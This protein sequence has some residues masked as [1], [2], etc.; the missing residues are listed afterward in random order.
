V[1]LTIPL[2]RP[3]DCYDHS[4]DHGEIIGDFL[5]LF[6]QSGTMNTTFE[7]YSLLTSSSEDRSGLP[8]LDS[9]QRESSLLLI[10]N[11]ESQ[12]VFE[13]IYE[14]SMVCN[15]SS[16]SC[17]SLTNEIADTILTFAG[18]HFDEFPTFPD[19]QSISFSDQ[20][21]A[22]N[23]P[24]LTVPIDRD[25]IDGL[26]TDKYSTAPEV[27]IIY[28]NDTGH[29][30]VSD[31]V[32][33]FEGF[34]P[35]VFDYH[36]QFSS[37]LS[38]SEGNFERQQYP[39]ESYF[40]QVTDDPELDPNA[41]SL[42]LNTPF[43]EFSTFSVK[44]DPNES[45]V[46]LKKAIIDLNGEPSFK[47]TQVLKLP[48]QNKIRRRNR[49]VV[50]RHNPKA[51]ND[52]DVDKILRIL[53]QEGLAC[54]LESFQKEDTRS[55]E[56]RKHT[57]SKKHD[58]LR[59][60]ELHFDRIKPK[61]PDFPF[62]DDF[63][64]SVASL[65]GYFQS[66]DYFR[67]SIADG[68]ETVVFLEITNWLYDMGL[69]D[70]HCLIRLVKNHQIPR[71]AR[72][73][74]NQQRKIVL[75]ALLFHTD[76][77]KYPLFK[78]IKRVVAGSKEVGQSFSMSDFTGY[79]TG[80][81][82]SLK[83]KMD[84]AVQSAGSSL[85][86]GF[87]TQTASDFRAF[88]RQAISDLKTYISTIIP[89]RF[90]MLLGVIAV[91]LIAVMIYRF[92]GKSSFET[93][94]SVSENAIEESI[95]S[96]VGQ[97]F[98]FTS[99][100]FPTLRSI[101]Q[102]SRD[103]ESINKFVR[104]IWTYVKLVLDSVWN[105]AFG[106]PF[107]DEGKLNMSTKQEIDKLADALKESSKADFLTNQTYLRKFIDSYQFM[108]KMLVKIDPKSS[109]YQTI[110]NLMLM[111][112]G[113]YQNA[114][115]AMTD[116]QERL[117]P[118]WIHIVGVPGAGKT[119]I[120]KPIAEFLFKK[121]N[122]DHTLSAK[123][124][125]I[126]TCEREFWDG[127]RGQFL[128]WTDDVFQT[129]D[130][131]MR[132]M[133]SLDLITMV[134]CA[135]LPLN[136]ANIEQKGCTYFNS[137]LMVT[138]SNDINWN[139]LGIVSPDALQRRISMKIYM[140][141]KVGHVSK[142]KA[143]AILSASFDVHVNSGVKN[144]VAVWT[145]TRGLDFL[146]LLPFVDKVYDDSQNR[147]LSD[148][149]LADLLGGFP[150]G[151]PPVPPMGPPPPP[152][153]PPPAGG[154][155]PPN[156]PNDP[157]VV[158]GNNAVVCHDPG[159]NGSGLFPTKTEEVVLN[160]LQSQADSRLHEAIL[161]A[162]KGVPPSDFEAIR[163]MF[164]FFEQCDKEKRCPVAKPLLPFL[165]QLHY[166]C[167]FY[168]VK[169][170]FLEFGTHGS[171][172]PSFSTDL[173]KV[174]IHNF[175]NG[176]SQFHCALLDSAV[177]ELVE[178]LLPLRE[179]LNSD[180]K[181]FLD[182]AIQFNRNVLPKHA[183]VKAWIGLCRRL[184]VDEKAQCFIDMD[185]DDDV[186]DQDP[187]P[188][189]SGNYIKY[190]W[191]SI[192]S[193]PPSISYLERFQYKYRFKELQ[194]L[195]Q[196]I[197]SFENFDVNF[198][199]QL[200]VSAKFGYVR[201]WFKYKSQL[202]EYLDRVYP[203]DSIGLVNSVKR[204][205]IVAGLF[206]TVFGTKLSVQDH[207]LRFRLTNTDDAEFVATELA[208]WAMAMGEGDLGRN[209]Y[210]GNSDAAALIDLVTQKLDLK[211]AEI[212]QVFVSLRTKMQS[213]A[214]LGTNAALGVLGIVAQIYATPLGGMVITVVTM[215]AAYIG[216]LVIVFKV[217]NY[218]FPPIEES[219]PFSRKKFMKHENERAQSEAV[220]LVKAQK[221]KAKQIKRVQ[222]GEKGQSLNENQQ[223][224][225][226]KIIN[227]NLTCIVRKHTNSLFG[228]GIRGHV[229]FIKGGL[230]VTNTH[231][232]NGIEKG[233]IL[234]IK[235]GELTYTMDLQRAL[236]EGKLWHDVEQDLTWGLHPLQF[237]T[238]ITKFFGDV[239]TPVNLARVEAEPGFGVTIVTCPFRDE[240]TDYTLVQ[241]VDDKP[242]PL[243]GSF[244]RVQVPG[245]SGDCGLV[246][247]DLNPRSDAIIS[248]IHIAGAT[249]TSV[250]CRMTK[251]YVLS[252]IKKFEQ[253]VTQKDQILLVPKKEVAQCMS[254]AYINPLVQNSVGYYHGLRVQGTFKKRY[255]Y[256]T[257]TELKPSLFQRHPDGPLFPD[258]Y[259]PA[260]LGKTG[261]IDP[262]AIFCSKM[263]NRKIHEIPSVVTLPEAWDGVFPKISIGTK[264]HQL[265]YQQAVHEC[266]NYGLEPIDMRT[267]SGSEF[268]HL[269]ISKEKL[270]AGEGHPALRDKIEWTLKQLRKGKAP[271]QYWLACSKDE[272]R[273]LLKAHNGSTRFFLIGCLAFQIV[274]RMYFGFFFNLHRLYRE[275]TEI[276]V[277]INPYSLEWH[278]LA[279][280]LGAKDPNVKVT[281]TD[282]EGWDLNFPVPVSIEF[283]WQAY[284][285]YPDVPLLHIQILIKVTHCTYIVIDIYLCV[286]VGMPSGCLITA[287]MNSSVNSSAHRGMAIEAVQKKIISEIP[288]SAY[289]GDDCVIPT[290]NDVYFEFIQSC[291]KEWFN[292][293]S[294]SSRKDD[295]PRRE[296]F[297]TCTF[298]KRT[299]TTD[300]NGRI[301]APLEKD[302]IYKM[303]TYVRARNDVE[304]IEKMEINHHVA[305]T[306]AS[307][308][309]EKF[310][311]VLQ[312]LLNSRWATVAPS[313][314]THWS[315]AFTRMKVLN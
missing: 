77:R 92:F 149:S 88:M 160:F 226:V 172:S 72:G 74:M 168:A 248:G 16:N 119:S 125:Y 24:V 253:T 246:Y 93:V 78:I 188:V 103:L 134:N 153:P 28:N 84:A 273:A 190:K 306:E 266:A 309:D 195:M 146:G 15:T 238:D 165:N 35:E 82:T 197:A 120:V 118:C 179:T 308:H 208:V 158:G 140:K 234:E 217:I 183:Q 48:S 283:A 4:K 166:Y 201:R 178:Q 240:M 157:P 302:S 128:T 213:F 278:T 58:R 250:L 231:M 300:A 224:K 295:V 143:D 38:N 247:C 89:V 14:P 55:V 279:M 243:K 268:V 52:E 290:E 135:P 148:I 102:W 81:F 147:K 57:N 87:W 284:I 255:S 41:S 115:A 236:D 299:F 113:I 141:P 275:N 150:P 83:A 156:P 304:L 221:A 291:R 40:V 277:G 232:F 244:I 162:E 199:E 270:L 97:S 258:K 107:T 198:A 177:R 112:S 137:H 44:T 171:F 256:P 62:V 259:A 252:C 205:A 216:C 145:I 222:Q 19:L 192:S 251:A 36:Q 105:W 98:G 111:Y 241:P 114:L 286:W 163:S 12:L 1:E 126:R 122:A 13:T 76:L 257:K 298:L 193:E 180:Q 229:L 80:F 264:Y 104:S 230:F 133:Q 123:D 130:T 174:L 186:S 303:L 215:A 3:Y 219:K 90:M 154:G 225:I 228:Q 263:A 272:L 282:I 131:Y 210:T 43:T 8:L 206:F 138:T 63:K 173:I 233:D 194:S 26:V 313:R 144:G 70:Y 274:L 6:V 117:A 269:H 73:K 95:I 129:T 265:T 110:R 32:T 31:G 312:N 235:L 280:F 218:F 204:S 227:N 203:Y 245:R 249:E 297:S 61:I 161:V 7:N 293:N 34:V 108:G 242:C 220:Y 182:I 64:L 307:L 47:T 176:N 54:P 39:V 20:R 260:M 239:P 151:P 202:S 53:E 132:M 276:A 288:R 45:P 294:T 136:M 237:G 164:S 155:L 71:P 33:K 214:V 127:Y 281:A 181:Y 296:P 75:N 85:A 5:K 99:F 96:E 60:L 262:V 142:G 170:P 11:E 66:R 91:T 292:W 191:F 86:A 167:Y 67:F 23:I 159:D 42:I 261:D 116:A 29:A 267:S 152:P 189:I 18:N 100:N 25:L 9:P 185:E 10:T 121:T 209:L 22:V 69:R 51:V 287:F 2:R 50:L 17:S 289:F 169:N 254:S 79:V 200:L 315:Y 211:T 30:I 271:M 37:M 124:I 311:N 305:L 301:V 314:A 68:T 175:L 223:A 109:L 94:V 184:P 139:N 196:S 285:R 59:D 27:D 101:G 310:F 106:H 65:H 207:V 49:K 21:P 46:L 212:T 187:N 56:K